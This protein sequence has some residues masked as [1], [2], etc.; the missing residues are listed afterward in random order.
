MA[1]GPRHRPESWNSNLPHL[2][3]EQGILV[4]AAKKKSKGSKNK[5]KK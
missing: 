3:H 2:Q 1:E 5:K 4:M